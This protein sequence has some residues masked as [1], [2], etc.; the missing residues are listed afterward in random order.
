MEWILPN[1]MIYEISSSSS[2]LLLG[3]STSPA[4]HMADVSGPA[5][6]SYAT[7]FLTIVKDLCCEAQ[8]TFPHAFRQF[9]TPYTA[10]HA[11]LIH[12]ECELLT[13]R[14]RLHLGIVSEDGRQRIFMSFRLSNCG[15][16]L[17]IVSF[18]DQK[19]L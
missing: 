13:I 6:K 11:T 3:L 10:L 7:G 18:I 16:F 12:P 1:A 5:P 19:R 9:Y 14:Q 15:S 17:F 8:Y 4:W 2:H